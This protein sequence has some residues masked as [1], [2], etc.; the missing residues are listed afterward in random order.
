MN[1]ASQR[2]DGQ[3]T[4]IKRKAAF[5]QCITREKYNHAFQFVIL[6]LAHSF[7]NGMLVNQVRKLSY[8]SSLGIA[9]QGLS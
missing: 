7:F 3:S 6:G 8:R 1:H 2:V 5:L 9:K 4:G